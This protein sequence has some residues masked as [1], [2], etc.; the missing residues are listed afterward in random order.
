VNAKAVLLKVRQSRK[1]IMVSSILPKKRTK[2]NT[3][4][5]EEAKDFGFCPFLEE[6]RIVL[7]QTKVSSI[8]LFETSLFNII[9][10]GFH[11]IKFLLDYIKVISIEKLRI[12]NMFSD[13][14][15]TRVIR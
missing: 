14:Q 4:S 8:F 13:L 15:L 12:Y 11:I 5:R 1:Q 6:L 10:R 3:L 2:L 7:F 9:L